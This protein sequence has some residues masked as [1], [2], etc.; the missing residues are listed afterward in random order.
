M[1]FSGESWMWH[2]STE[3][4]KPRHDCAGFDDVRLPGRR[5]TDEGHLIEKTFPDFSLHD[6]SFKNESSVV[7]IPR[8]VLWC[9]RHDV[10]EDPATGARHRCQEKVLTFEREK[11][12][13]LSEK[14][15]WVGHQVGGQINCVAF[16]SRNQQL[17][18]TLV[19][20][21]E[22]EVTGRVLWWPKQV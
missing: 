8:S 14:W 5:T 10:G 9:N 7:S 19:A 1:F 18:T 12:Q 15:L 2:R 22:G 17:S 21:F 20:S 6:I 3:L 16:K 11:L 4:K 13:Q